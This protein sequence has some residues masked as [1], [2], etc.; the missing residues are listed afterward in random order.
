MFDI[1]LL[2]TEPTMPRARALATKIVPAYIGVLLQ[3][4]CSALSRQ[5]GQ[6]TMELG[7]TLI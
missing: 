4:P 3:V 1:V 2:S 5:P 7:V 6:I